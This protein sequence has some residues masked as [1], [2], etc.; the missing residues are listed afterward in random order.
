MSQPLQATPVDSTPDSGPRMHSGALVAL[1]ASMAT[2]TAFFAAGL[3]LEF[4]RPG[5]AVPAFILFSLPAG[6]WWYGVWNGLRHRRPAPASHL[7]LERELGFDLICTCHGVASTVFF[8]PEH[9]SGGAQLD[10]LLFV[11]NYASR[12]RIAEFKVGP[13]AGLGLS[14]ARVLRLHLAAGQAAVYRLSLRAGTTL[15]AGEHD[16]PVV[17][18][19]QCPAGVGRRL[20][21]QQKP[22]YDIGRT[23]FAAPFTID[24]EPAASSA[25]S[26]A[27]LPPDAYLSLASVSEPHPRLDVLQTLVTP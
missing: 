18:H 14:G 10:L 2:L 23:R 22:L 24:K 6:W 19:V 27:P 13:H 25:E 4:D 11:E 1:A 17:L 7:V 21:G 15:R 5:L 3:C 12:Q 8:H 16:L 9:G 26:A 20:S